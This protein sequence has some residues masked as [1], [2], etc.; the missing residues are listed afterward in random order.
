V[1]FNASSDAMLAACRFPPRTLCQRRDGPSLAYQ[2]FGEGPPLVVSWRRLATARLAG[3]AVHIAARVCAAAGA[4]EVMASRTVRDL[5]V[6]SGIE[7]R[8][9]G[10][11]ELKGVPGKWELFAAAG[12]DS[13]PIEVQPEAPPT[14]AAD[15]V[16]LATA[17]RAPG[18]LR[19][20]GR[21][22]A[23]R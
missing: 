17:R 5:V 13:D 23:R 6:G 10:E 18:L 15:R 22:S 7:L 9:R 16:V 14:K 21:I 12:D 3:V 2:V 19:L 20:V 8:G 4:G 11:Q 1:A